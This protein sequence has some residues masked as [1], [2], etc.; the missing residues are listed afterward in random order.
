[1]RDLSVCTIIISY[2]PDTEQLAC[3]CEKLESQCQYVVVDNGSDPGLL[4][5]LE[6]RLTEHGNLLPLN[7]NLGIAAAQNAGVDFACKTLAIRPTYYL[8]LD[9]D[10]MPGNDLVSSLRREY[11]VA[12]RSDPRVAAVGPALLDVR[13]GEFLRLHQETLGIYIKRHINAGTNG[14]LH[15]VAS[16]NSSG[17]FLEAVVLEETG[18]FLEKLFIDHVDTEWSHRARHMGYN[19]YVSSRVC[20]EHEMGRGLETIWMFG[21]QQFPSRAPI[22]HYYLF[23]NNVFLLSQ[24]QMSRTWRFWSILKLLLT[25]AYFG[26]VSKDRKEQRKMMI[27]GIAAGRKRELGSFA[28]PPEAPGAR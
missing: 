19:L 6:K 13:N 2:H 24:P 12:K 26:T 5:E 21:E 1:M 8:F 11:E 9:Q 7:G 23:R 22:R 10:S 15:R 25:F 27:Q 28:P 14:R 3:L 20:L 17:T 16:L 4:V 18:G